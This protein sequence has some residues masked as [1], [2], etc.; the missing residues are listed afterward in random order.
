MVVL[1]VG[2]GDEGT[3][4]VTS[5]ADAT[6]TTTS[7]PVAA[8]PEEER[9]ISGPDGRI[10]DFTDADEVR[11]QIQIQERLRE[12]AILSDS[13]M[14]SAQHRRLIDA[15]SV[16]YAIEVRNDAGQVVGYYTTR[17]IAAADYPAELAEAKAVVA[18]VDRGS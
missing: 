6:T 10:G 15:L 13:S 18:K 3:G 12:M 16:I 8:R 1:L 11:Q 14:S 9:W 7:P 17:Y 2:C 4:Q 5:G